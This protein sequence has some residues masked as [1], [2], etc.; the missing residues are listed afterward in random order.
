MADVMNSTIEQLT[1]AGFSED[2]ARSI[3][4]LIEKS[5]MMTPRAPVQHVSGGAVEK[6]TQGDALRQFKIEQLEK[7]LSQHKAITI[8][9]IA[10]LFLVVL[11]AI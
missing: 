1:S 5:T 2:Q 6:S 3:A 9:A 4:A 11:A 8:I 7:E 10:G